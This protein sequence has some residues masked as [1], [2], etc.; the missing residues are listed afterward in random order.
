MWEVIG[1]EVQRNAENIATGITMFAIKP[2]KEG[3][4]EGSKARRVWYRPQEISYKPV[5]GDKVCID[6]E[7]RGKYEIVTDIY[8][9][10]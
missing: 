4:G 5:L 3:A 8:K 9:V 2:Y 6:T 10:G 1:Y 7:T